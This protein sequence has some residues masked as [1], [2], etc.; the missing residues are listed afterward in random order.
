MG[1][2][3]GARYS[4]SKGTRKP[5]TELVAVGPG[6]VQTRGSCAATWQRLLQARNSAKILTCSFSA[7]RQE[8]GLQLGHK[9]AHG[10]AAGLAGRHGAAGAAGAP[11]AGA[12]APVHRFTSSAPK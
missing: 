7:A 3:E 1:S 8:I 11:A 6:L 5:S 12:G 10:G 2:G 4:A 9:A